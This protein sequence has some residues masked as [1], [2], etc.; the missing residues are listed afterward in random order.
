MHGSW[1]SLRNRAFAPFRF[2][3]VP[4]PLLCPLVFALLSGLY[5]ALPLLLSVFCCICVPHIP[6]F[7]L[8]SS[9]TSFLPS[10][11]GRPCKFA[12]LRRAFFS[13]FSFFSRYF[14]A[15]TVHH[16]ARRLSGL[17]AFLSLVGFAPPSSRWL[18]GCLFSC[19][20]VPYSSFVL[21]LL[22]IF[23]FHSEDDAGASCTI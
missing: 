5:F 19:M 4:L 6:A 16:L 3:S 20:P 17:V 23:L 8:C 21:P 11:L 2:V 12:C 22:V 15:L 10:F 7:I 14:V 9:L 13:P 18:R 1:L